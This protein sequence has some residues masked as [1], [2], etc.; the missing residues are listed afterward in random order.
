MSLLK[1]LQS[2]DI[3]SGQ[4][5]RPVSHRHHK[6]DDINLNEPVDE[7]SFDAFWDRVVEDI[8]KDPQWFTFSDE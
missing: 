3:D 5:D 4:E 2:Q 8:H 6:E 7:A 1:N